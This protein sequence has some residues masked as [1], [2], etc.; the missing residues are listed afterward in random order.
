MCITEA[1]LPKDAK[2]LEVEGKG[3]P[4]NTSK[5][6]TRY[7]CATCGTSVFEKGGED[8][9][10][11]GICTGA[12]QKAEGMVKLEH[13]LFVA[14]TRDGGLMHWLSDGTLWEGWNFKSRE[15]TKESAFRQTNPE[16]KPQRSSDKLH[17]RCHC[18]GVEF[19]I[20]APSKESS[21]MSLVLPD[22]L[23]EPLEKNESDAWW[24]RSDGTK[25]LADNCACNACRL[26]SGYDIQSWAFVTKANIQ[27]TDGSP[28]DFAMGT[29]KQYNSSEGVW[30][31]F[32]GVCGAV[33]FYHND[34]R[35]G[36]ID[37]SVGLM[38]AESGA[39]AEEWLEWPR[40][41]VSYAEYAQN[42][43]L[44]ESLTTGLKARGPV[45]M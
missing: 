17:C 20:M 14:D 13:Q 30:R 21:N 32:C 26:G 38:E 15:I 40:D 7:F 12:L 8:P 41:E 28:L 10:T 3:Q 5:A 35:P 18:G 16:S 23:E 37:V 39:R 34:E 9:D 43:S 44:I 2:P 29:L 6:L 36:L 25:Y 19:D 45:E 27:Q 22:L 31:E 42:K 11:V 4:Y 33:V 24:L 1:N